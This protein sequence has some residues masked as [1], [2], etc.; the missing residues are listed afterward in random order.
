MRSTFVPVFQTA[1][2]IFSAAASVSQA[3][4]HDAAPAILDQLKAQYKLVKL[5]RDANGIAVVE[6]GTVLIVQQGG[7]LG[8]PPQKLENCAA[9]YQD[10]QLHAAGGFCAALVKRFSRYFQ[11]GDKVYPLKIDANLKKEQLSF[12]VVACD[13][14]N[15]TDPA[16]YYK[17]EVVFQ[18]GAGYLEIAQAGDV[19]RVIG[20]VF[21]IDATDPPPA[22]G[23]PTPA[24]A[25]ATT[26]VADAP[27][28]PIAPPPP[29]AA[30]QP[31]PT[32]QPGQTVDQVVAALGQPQ[33]I[34]N[35]GAKQIYLFK[36]LK[37]TFTNG[38]MSDVE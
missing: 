28:P 38:K 24:P 27:P 21:S 26:R 1:I 36:D 5:G 12:K 37:V 6:P 17:S 7:L 35:L 8:V 15:G 31:P 16:S 29:P 25:P 13:T 14:C 23:A 20:Q 10:G 3:I 22:Q 11:K 19:Q 18:F 2:V 34:V 32:V 33:K 9:R 30:D 4:A